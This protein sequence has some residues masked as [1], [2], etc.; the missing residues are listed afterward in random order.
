MSS[1]FDLV[2]IG[3]GPGGY[4]CAIRAAQL[5]M[6][7]ALIE[8]RG[9]DSKKP[10]LGG[11]C[12]N[13][14]CIPSKALL[15]SSER[16]ADAA[17]HFS[18]HGIGVGKLSL[19]VAQMMKRKDGVVTSLTDGI[20]Y[21]MKKN[22]I[23]VLAGT[24][25]LVKPG[26]VAVTDA[27]GAKQEFTAKHVVLAMGSV[28]IE[29]PFLKVDGEKIVTSDHAI[30]FEKVPEHLIVVGGG[31]IGLELGSVW[32]RLGAKVT[33]VEFLP[34]ICPFLDADV[35]KELQ[36]V[37]TKQ[38]LTFALETAV[39]GSQLGKGGVTLTATDKAKATVTY[40]G[41][42]V[43]VAVGRRPLS[44]GLAAAGV[45]LDER[46]R[47][48]VDHTFQTNLPGVYAIGDL[49]PGPMLA[50]KAEEEGVALAEMLAGQKPII[51]HHLIPNVVYTHPEVATIGLT[52]REAE[53]RKIAVTKGRFAFIANG[54]AKASGDTDGFVKVLADA[55]TDRLLGAAII[56][57]RA[58]DLIAEI[59]AVMSFGGSSEDI[60]RL[61]HAHPTVSEAVKEA[62]LDAQGRVLH[63]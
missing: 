20:A 13:V 57:P 3:A 48:T 35:A 51:D 30:A 8:K 28:P 45:T 50:H 15:D 11:T 9:A 37:L 61:C 31:V 16:Y 59:A 4:V 34:Q 33:V 32:A 7:V 40:S 39:T 19:D 36:K 25:A 46:K 47:V 58:S 18:E 54:R 12:L 29:L 44:D 49:I 55:T 27:A 5:G 38:G 62:A 43:L 6:S 41:D 14:G 21:L 60:A 26:V 63:G 23:T 1:S 42:R 22:K 10:R 17:K 24:G 56:G 52:E 2:I 53:Q